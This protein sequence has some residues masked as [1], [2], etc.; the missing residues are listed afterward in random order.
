MRPLHEDLHMSL[1]ELWDRAPC[2]VAPV[3]GP[4]GEGTS[5]SFPAKT[6]MLRSTASTCHCY[7]YPLADRNTKDLLLQPQD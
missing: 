6:E 5:L 3:T 1:E 2:A 4:P 7:E